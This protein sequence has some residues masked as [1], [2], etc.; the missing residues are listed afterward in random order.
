MREIPRPVRVVH[1][2]GHVASGTYR[3]RLLA[4]STSLMLT[5]GVL[6]IS[7]GPAVAVDAKGEFRVSCGPVS[8]QGRF[9]PIVFPDLNPA[10]H[11]HE[12]YGSTET[13]PSSTPQSLLNSPTT[14][15]D[16]G[17]SSGYWHPTVYFNG[18]RAPAPRASIYYTQKTAEKPLSDMQVWPA[19]LRIIAG[20]GH[21]DGPQSTFI[22]W[23][24]CDNTTINREP[25]APTCPSNSSG[26]E[27]HIRF[28]DCWDGVNLDS[29][30]HQAHMS[31]AV[32][33]NDDIYRC[34]STHPVML[35]YLIMKF[36]WDGQFPAGETV[37]LSSGPSYTMHADFM[38]AWDQDRLQHLFEV[39]VKTQTECGTV[40]ENDFV[41][42]TTTTNAPTTTSG[43]TTTI[44]AT[45]TTAATTTTVATTTTAATTTT[46]ATTTTAATTTTLAAT[47]TTVTTTTTTV[48]TT[49][50]THPGKG[51]KPPKP[52]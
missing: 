48:P 4:A 46:L 30:N 15:S 10:G 41:G 25:T 44:E 13:G 37:T 52:P 39:C 17:D 49:T 32:E 26:L 31:Y 9:D 40:D 38:N 1:N 51:K 47:T 50:T 24:G 27:V 34:D 45:T 18:V 28:P 42:T 33:G 2:R 36:R 7:T 14:C 35:P 5:I 19:G 22:M 16:S 29:A 3:S 20:N 23:W 8:H 6:A 12:F 43:A 11:N 21:A